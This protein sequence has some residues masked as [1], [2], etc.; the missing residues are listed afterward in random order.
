MSRGDEIVTTV[1][2]VPADF[3]ATLGGIDGAVPPPWRASY[4]ISVSMATDLRL[5]YVIDHAAALP[6]V[7]RIP[8]AGQRRRTLTRLVLSTGILTAH[9]DAAD[10]G[11]QRTGSWLCASAGSVRRA[12]PLEAVTGG[13]EITDTFRESVPASVWERV[14]ERRAVFA[15]THLQT[16]ERGCLRGNLRGRLGGEGR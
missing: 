7:W 15:A 13:S 10:L 14:A 5:L 12:L 11:E 3:T 2:A 9:R 16:A 1:G 4:V 8:L 6:W